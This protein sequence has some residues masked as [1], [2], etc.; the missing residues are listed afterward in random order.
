[1]INARA[2]SKGIPKKNIKPFLGKP[3][4]IHS[5]EVAL[6]SKKIDKVL[7]ST[8]CK[9]IARIAKD[10]GAFVPFMRPKKLATSKSL[11]VDTIIYNLK[12]L[13]TLLKKKIDI[14]V[15]LQPTAPL[16]TAKDVE[17]CI[18]LIIK[19]NADTV[20]SITDVGSR[21][22]TGIY[23]LKNKDELVPFVKLNKS[24]FNRQELEKIY[25][26]TG[27]VYVIKRNVLINEKAIYGK[28]ILGYNIPEER[29]FNLDTLF[30][31]KLAEL[32]AKFNKK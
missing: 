24:G 17:G 11:Q 1:M 15:L 25:W 19:K 9:K 22:P 30:D 8:D 2:G 16:R 12:K 21:H 23:K 4:I 10:N 26:R 28:K 14:V 31:W 6:Q 27:S 20:I 5:I 29:S 32:W 7:V 3:L 18:N 13:E